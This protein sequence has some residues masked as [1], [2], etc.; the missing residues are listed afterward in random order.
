MASA[1]GNGDLVCGRVDSA[2]RLV[3]A[4]T[5]LGRLQQEAGASVGERLMLPQLAAVA[6]LVRKL[7]IAVA[8]PAVVAGRDYDVELWV[9]GEPDGDDV[10]ITIESWRRRP[11]QGP[12]LEQAARGED[13]LPATRGEW[14]TDTELRITELSADLAELLGVGVGEA[15]GQPMTRLLRL[16][17][18]EDGAMPLLLAV[19][20]RAPFSEQRAVGR[21]GPGTQL[22]LEGMPVLAADGSLAG[23]RGRALPEHKAHPTAANEAGNGVLGLDPA[24]DHA[25]R[26]PIDRIIRAAEGIADRSEGPLRSDYAAYAG[27]IAAAARHLL[28]VIRSMVDQP[29]ELESQINLGASAD[30]A[31][32]LVEAE[33]EENSVILQREGAQSLAAVGDPRAIIQILVNLLANAVRHSP[34]GGRVTLSLVAGTEFA[35]ATISDEGPGIAPTDQERI[36]ERFEQAQ[37]GGGAG[38]GLAIARRLARSMGGD[39]T[40]VSVP[41]EGARFTL[42]VPLAG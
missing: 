39:I 28:S 3:E 20:S 17:E 11:P 22:V 37:P 19:A 5:M 23:Y 9:R 14:A 16:L 21:S 41:G 7:G 40:L 31:F 18:G 42:S 24:L 2:G 35:S 33:A 29:P 38:L 36:F 6:R 10:L 26:S 15:N 27:D 12:R 30:E 32:G 1:A 13:L 34:P 8:R 25:L 4:D